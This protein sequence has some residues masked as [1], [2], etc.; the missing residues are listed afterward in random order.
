MISAD[1]RRALLQLRRL[2]RIGDR[3][4]AALM[5]AAGSARA[6]L[7]RLQLDGARTGAADEAWAEAQLARAAEIGA[8]FITPQDDEYPVLLRRIPDPPTYLFVLGRVDLL[9]TAGVAIVG[10]RRCS[11][12]GRDVA[13]RFGRDLAARGVTVI[14]GMARGIDGAAHDGA[15]EAA[16]PGSGGTIAVLGCGVDRVYPAAHR[17][18]YERLVRHGAILSELPLGVAPEAGSFPRRNRIISGLALGVIVAEASERSGALITA[19]CAMEQNREVFAIPGE[20]T[21]PGCAGGLSLLR[22]GAC[23]ARHAQDVLDELAH[24]LPTT[25]PDAAPQTPAGGD[26][27][28]GAAAR[29]LR[30]LDTGICQLDELAKDSGL[31]P[32]ALLEEL[33]RLELAG[34][35]QAHPGGAYRRCG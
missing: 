18:L 23:L 7:R 11:P 34:L 26:A 25:A 30:R 19:R 13:R 27:Q 29:L 1:E 32:A 12:Y 16:A 10:S 28:S 3:R 5:A 21:N 33:L 35:V 17:S 31:A 4:C 2:P 20:V 6:A 24:V 22:D 8:H 15:L 14:S 9:H